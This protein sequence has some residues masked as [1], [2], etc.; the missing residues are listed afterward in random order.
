M[1]FK[2]IELLDL[3][4]CPYCGGPGQLWREGNWGSYIECVDCGAQTPI[5]E[6]K[7]EAER[8]EAE[9]RLAD[10]WNQ[11]KVVSFGRGE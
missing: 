11:G 5:V 7:S 10:A 1:D 4:D 2:D 8:T 9:K 3:Q 6:Y